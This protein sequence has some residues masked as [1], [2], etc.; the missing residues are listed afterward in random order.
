MNVKNVEMLAILVKIRRIA[1][2]A[3]LLFISLKDNV[4]SVHRVVPPVYLIQIVNP[5]HQIPIFSSIMIACIAIN[6]L[7]DVIDVRMYFNV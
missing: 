6:L 7:R 3:L 1:F 4:L 5:V 2:L